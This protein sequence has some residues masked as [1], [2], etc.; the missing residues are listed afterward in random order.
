MNKQHTFINY[1]NKITKQKNEVKDISCSNSQHIK[2]DKNK[3]DNIY[4]IHTPI[5]NT[6]E[7]NR[8]G[9]DYIDIISDIEQVYENIKLYE[10]LIYEKWHDKI[11]IVFYISVTENIPYINTNN[12][13]NTSEPGIKEVIN[14]VPIIQIWNTQKEKLFEYIFHTKKTDS[15]VY[16]NFYFEGT[17]TFHLN[18]MI[19]LLCGNL[20]K[21]NLD[22]YEIIEKEEEISFQGMDTQ[23]KTNLLYVGSSHGEIYAFNIKTLNLLKIIKFKCYHN[24]KLLMNSGDIYYLKIISDKM[25]IYLYESWD[26]G[27]DK[28]LIIN[29]LND[30]NE[31]ELALYYEAYD[32]KTWHFTKDIHEYNNLLYFSG[33]TGGGVHIFDTIKKE[34]L[35]MIPDICYFIKSFK[36]YMNIQGKYLINCINSYDNYTIQVF[37]LDNNSLL[38]QVDYFFKFKDCQIIHVS[39]IENEIH[40]YKINTTSNNSINENKVKIIIY[41]LNNI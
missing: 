9:N 26:T 41:K 21:I 5:I 25:Y 37:D 28:V 38:E 19:F 15:I 6:I 2:L 29:D 31:D 7:V 27:I 23:N 11:I 20:F 13:T 22:N 10:V 3:F 18:N 1:H 8:E 24:D 33:E 35:K 16:Y 17:K 36:N 30:Y 40:F 14:Y 4:S 34:T 32:L 12:K 39:I